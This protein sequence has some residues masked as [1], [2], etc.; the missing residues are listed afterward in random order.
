MMMSL[1]GAALAD[2]WIGRYRTITTGKAVVPD[3]Q[4]PSA[5]IGNPSA[6]LYADGHRRHPAVVFFSVGIQT[7]YHRGMK[8]VGL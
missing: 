7:K 6:L 4:E 2:S 5:Q 8:A 1:L 3:G